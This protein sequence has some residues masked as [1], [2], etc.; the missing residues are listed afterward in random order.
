MFVRKLFGRAPSPNGAQVLKAAR[1][2]FAD[3]VFVSGVV[4]RLVLSADRAGEMGACVFLR[5]V[6]FYTQIRFTHVLKQSPNPRKSRL[7]FLIGV[8]FSFGRFFFQAPL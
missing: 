5:L 3:A 6:C 1:G 4:C 2:A 7:E 8:F